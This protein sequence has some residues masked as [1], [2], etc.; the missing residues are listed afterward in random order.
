M[1]VVVSEK[2]QRNDGGYGICLL[3]FLLNVN[4][5]PLKSKKMHSSQSHF[6]TVF[7][8]FSSLQKSVSCQCFLVCPSHN[9]FHSRDNLGGLSGLLEYLVVV[10]LIHTLVLIPYLFLRSEKHTNFS[11]LNSICAPPTPFHISEGNVAFIFLL[12]SF[13]FPDLT[14]SYYSFSHLSFFCTL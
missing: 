4:N 7:I 6:C 9:H 1:I 14:S 10:D 8:W 3:D 13:I 12:R 11:K 2:I 5:Y